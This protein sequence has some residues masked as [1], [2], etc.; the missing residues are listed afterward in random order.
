MRLKPIGILAAGIL[1]TGGAVAGEQSTQGASQPQAQQQ[2]QQQPQAQQQSRSPE[3]VKQVQE[4]LSA[5]GHEAGPSD[6][7]LGPKTQAALKEFQEKEG[8]QASGQL[9]QQTLAALEIYTPEG[10]ASSSVGA[11][12]QPETQQ[13]KQE[14]PS[15][16]Q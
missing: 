8:L 16:K 11:S 7:V 2:S 9:D 14:E 4:K 5:A 15:R 1:A 12:S 6:G 13:Q 3:L 10:S